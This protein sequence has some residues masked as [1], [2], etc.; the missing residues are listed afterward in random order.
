MRYP[1][2]Y[3]S[4]SHARIASQSPWTLPREAGRIIIIKCLEIPLCCAA[5]QPVLL[6][7]TG[8]SPCACRTTRHSNIGVRDG[9]M[10][11]HFLGGTFA[12]PSVH[13]QAAHVNTYEGERAVGGSS[14]KGRGLG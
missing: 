6:N 4:A 11:R 8:L 5:N 9:P 7:R 3:R 13:S 1:C 2:V 14:E 12:Y 10:A